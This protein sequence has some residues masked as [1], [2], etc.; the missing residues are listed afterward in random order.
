MKPID[1]IDLDSVRGGMGG[2]L[3]GTLAQSAGPI[4][5][6]VASII[7][8]AKSGGGSQAA[9]AT[10]AAAAPMGP[11]PSAPV[12]SGGGGVSVSVSINGVQ[13]AVQA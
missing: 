8:A 4:L 7:G 10:Q 11:P 6:G 5:N 1:P 2:A 13:T 12:S 3:L 9:A